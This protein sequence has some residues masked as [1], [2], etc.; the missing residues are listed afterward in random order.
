M[1]TSYKGNQGKVGRSKPGA[2]KLEPTEIT[3]RE[4]VPVVLAFI[5]VA[6]LITI[7][8]FISLYLRFADNC[9]STLSCVRHTHFGLR[10]VEYLV[11][12]ANIPTELLDHPFLADVLSGVVVLALVILLCGL[13]RIPLFGSFSPVL[14]VTT[15]MRQRTGETYNFSVQ[16]A[17]RPH[18]IAIHAKGRFPGF[19]G[20]ALIS[21][22]LDLPN[23]ETLT[24]EQYLKPIAEPAKRNAII[25]YVF[26]PI[27][28]QF[29]PP[30]AGRVQLWFGYGSGPETKVS[31]CVSRRS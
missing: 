13:F 29:T 16:D 2:P 26:D 30:E 1:S 4:S 5:V 6:P 3:M 27:Y 9:S 7:P 31:L 25:E 19:P 12:P 20:D 8:W 22:K 11:G 17:G 14:N 18:R 28:F 21:L 10:S 23:V 15:H 24:A